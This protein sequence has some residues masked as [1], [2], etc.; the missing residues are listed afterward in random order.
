MLRDLHVRNLAMLAEVGLELGEGLNI[1]SGETGAGK[2]LVVDSLALLA[3]ARASSDLIG[4]AGD[5]MSV[6]GV[7]SL[8]GEDW[9]ESLVAAGIDLGG[10]DLVVRREVNREG[11][12]RVFINDQ[13]VTLA[14]LAGVAP[15]LLHI[16]T[17]REEL[18]LLSAELQRGWL[19][20]SGGEGAKGVLARVSHAY[21][22][23]REVADR[24][25]RVAGDDR[26]RSERADLIRF[27]LREID[28]AQINADEEE[29]LRRERAV[30]RNSE[31]I[32]DALASSFTLL[33]D[34]EGAASERLARASEALA[35]IGEWEAGAEDWRSLL[36]EMGIQIEEIA[37]GLRDRLDQVEADPARL[38]LVET[39]LAVLERLMK[40][41]GG[42][43]REMLHYRE[44][45][46]AELESI[47]L[48]SQGREELAKRVDAAREEYTHAAL[49]LAAARK[50]WA[51][52]LEA[53]VEEEFAELALSRARFRVAV[54]GPPSGE[55]EP[56]ARGIDRVEYLFAP[57][58]GEEAAPLARIASGGELSRVFLA[59][60]LAVRGRGNAARTTLVFDEI[61]AGIG[62]AE[63]AA[64]GRKLQRL[65]GGGQILVV[66]HLPQVA[67][68]ADRHFKVNK[69]LTA[70]KTNI[71]VEELSGERRIEEIARMLAGRRITGLSR[72]HAEE[73]ISGAARRR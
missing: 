62:G 53:R 31:A 28:S 3:G 8:E 51:R 19:D 59:L 49:E 1:L 56:T 58:P 63:A 24:L 16:H 15:R 12:N 55:W 10:D 20:R 17:Q 22:A 35:K 73:L 52:E 34:D 46:A 50:T 41:Y 37:H 61:D 23:Y 25:A 21:H 26:M 69:T 27:Q 18:G 29:H 43:T 30:L 68:H 13:Q 48:D 2:S 14:L 57:N 47:D 45:I 54:E 44:E 40:K 9:R 71:E 72:S 66:T 5:L 38:D 42:S 32:R 33:Y 6:T 65:A 70:K 60:Q 4:R 39:R 64:L 67:S 36:D 11:R 7:F